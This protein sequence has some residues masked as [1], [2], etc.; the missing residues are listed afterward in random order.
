[1]MLDLA[2]SGEDLRAVIGFHS[3]LTTVR[4]AAPG[5]FKSKVLVQVGAEDPVIPAEQ[6]LAFE[7]EMTAAGAD[8]RMIVYGGCGHSF[9]NPNGNPTG[10]AGFFYHELSDRRSWR[11]M[12]DLLDEALV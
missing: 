7:R 8:W 11:A 10:T 9:T 2:R 1:M 6:R 5:A 4:P 3:A 12:I